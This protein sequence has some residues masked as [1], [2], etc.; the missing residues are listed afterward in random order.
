V[1]ASVAGVGLAVGTTFGF[2][3]LSDRNAYQNMPTQGLLDTGRRNALLS[4]IGFGAAVLS[5]GVAVVLYIAGRS[6][7]EPPRSAPTAQPTVGLRAVP[8][9][10]AITF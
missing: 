3:A 1:S 8:G 7:A 10:L 5:A 9:G 6:R 4:D 2:L